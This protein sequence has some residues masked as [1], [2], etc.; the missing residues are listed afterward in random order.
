MSF[1][2]FS[3]KDGQFAGIPLQT[4][5][6]GDALAEEAKKHCLSGEFNVP[7]KLNLLALFKKFTERKFDIYFSEKNK[8]RCS[9]LQAKRDK[10]LYIKKHMIS[11]LMSFFSPHYT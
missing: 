10:K 6:L 5:M 8:M 1:E 3:D 11:A 7:N 9:I 4:M 2:N